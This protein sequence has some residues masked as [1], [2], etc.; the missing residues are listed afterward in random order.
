MT[1][2]L[3]GVPN[4]AL[5]VV[6]V[7]DVAQSH[8]RAMESKLSNGNRFLLIAKGMWMAEIPQIL[9]QEFGK[10]GYK[11]PT[12]TFGKFLL[13]IASIFDGN[14]KAILPILGKEMKF[15]NEK[16]IKELNIEYMDVNKTILDMAWSLIKFG[17][18]QDKIK[19][20]KLNKYNENNS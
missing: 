7:R 19:D 15:K 12:R 5:G 3:P 14:A 2:K 17:I 16:S 20:T 4:M 6:D 9:K 8:I 13:S 10:F 11:I 1:N 18:V